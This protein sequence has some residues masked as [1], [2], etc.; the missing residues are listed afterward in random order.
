LYVVAIGAKAHR[1]GV[2]LVDWAEGSCL[3]V[4]KQRYAVV[5][6]AGDDRI[7][8]AVAVQI[9]SAPV[10]YAVTVGINTK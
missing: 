4:F 6:G 7:K 2:S 8:C 1:E 10:R 3:H 5:C 9:L